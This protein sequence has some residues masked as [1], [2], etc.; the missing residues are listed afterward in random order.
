MSA[1]LTRM[2]IAALVL[3]SP[4]CV[5]KLS[6]RNAPLEN[7]GVTG[8]PAD[9][10]R[11]QVLG[12]G[13][14]GSGDAQP[15][16][17]GRYDLTTP[18]RATFD[19][20]GNVITARFEGSELTVGLEAEA[21][22]IFTAKIDDRDPI[23]FEAAPGKTGYVLATGLGPGPHEVVLHRNSEALFGAVTF[24]GFG[25]GAGGKPLPPTERP[26][27]IEIIGDSITCG[28]GSEGQNATCPFDIPKDPAEPTK[29]RVAV[30]E[31][32]YLAYGSIAAREL[33]ADAVTLCFSGKGV[34]QNYRE[35]GFGEGPDVAAA[36]P[37][38]DARTT[39][40]AYWERTRAMQPD[41][42]RWDFAAEPEPQVVVI[43]LGTNDFARDLNQDSIADGID[44][45]RFR[46]AY[47]D[48]VQLVRQRRPNAHVFLALSPM[49]TDNFPLDDARKDFRSIL[50]SIAADFEGRGD[51]KVY[52]M[53]LVEMG[54][55]YGL[56]CD[57]HPN[58]EVHR[59]MADQLVGAIRSKT[60][61]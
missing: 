55:R 59:I 46:Q 2:A 29:N 10:G 13:G 53:E 3:L 24:T 56:G 20:S 11:I 45:G 8:E 48:F 39:M 12:R 44:Q 47:T 18:G 37:D 38:P 54:T 33:S 22:I 52:F 31:N 49:I 58:L 5:I 19:W 41:G 6:D 26:R 21:Y 42:P 27:R 51:R 36:P 28:Y 1:G 32:Q 9:C 15:R 30:S 17:V 61:W 40:P 60:C 43:S 23:K 14:P 50:R 4:A 57:Y 25:Y 7:G 16:L 35:G 34:Y